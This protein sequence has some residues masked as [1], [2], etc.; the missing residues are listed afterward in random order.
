MA[1]GD[2]APQSDRLVPD[3]AGATRAGCQG[4]AGV[5]RGPRRLRAGG[6]R[7]PGRDPDRDRLRGAHRPGG[8]HAAVRRG[9][10]QPGGVAAVVGAVRRA[11]AGLSRRGAAARRRGPRLRRGRGVAG[12][13]SVRRPAGRDH[14]NRPLWRL[15]A[16][17][18]GARPPRLHA[19]ARRR[20]GRARTLSDP[21]RGHHAMTRLHELAA[22]GTSPWLDNIRR[23]WLNS[24]TFRQ[25][26]DDGVVGVTSNPTI[27][28]KA[29][30][31]S[32]DYDE[33]IA[34]TAAP[35][36]DPGDVFFE[37]AIADV[38]EAAD[39]LRG[40]YDATGHVD[41]FVSFELPP[42]MAN[43]TAA[44]TRA[45]PEFWERIGR[46]NIFIKIPGTAEGVPA[47]EES[48]AVGIN[49]NVTLLFS[50]QNYE[51]IHWAFIRG[52]ERRVQEGQPIDDVHSVASFFVS[53]V[54]TAVDA[55]LPEGSPLR[56]KAAIANAKLA[57]QR[58]LEIKADDSWQALAA[59]GARVQRPLWASTGTKNPAYSDVLYIDNLI[60]PECVNTMPDPT[61][62][63]FLDHG[64]VE[65]TVDRDVDQA[66]RELERLHEAGIDL[67]E[68]TRRLE[69]DGVKS[70]SESF[71]SLVGTLRERLDRIGARGA[72]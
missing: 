53:R 19:A 68:V 7:G 1:G 15:R 67:D 59:H 2:G 65:R 6:R 69:L 54:D 25:W 41:G 13:G 12:V 55:K 17:P 9:C 48:I 36:K 32:D 60:G 56:G 27:F 8:A 33:A 58:Y 22:A 39:Q 52:L 63:A 26:V 50:L 70:F 10:H 18:D 20:R 57:Y 23:S 24:G 29:I 46:P 40:A 49:V 42:S 64:V 37:L 47:I 62:A 30:A 34:A 4:A 21:R 61:I 51:A 45:T 44:S 31:D 16:R 72:A 5:R 66:R 3:Q 35:G 11:V 43:D 38:Q 71:D 28:Q 14:R